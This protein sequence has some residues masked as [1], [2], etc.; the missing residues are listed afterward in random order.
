[1]K[2]VNLSLLTIWLGA[3]LVSIAYGFFALLEEGR[4]LGV[5]LLELF[6]ERSKV[7]SIAALLLAYSSLYLFFHPSLR[8]ALPKTQQGKGEGRP[9]EEQG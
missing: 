3:I 4:K 5:P 9:E 7:F 6:S 2:I 1:M 8:I